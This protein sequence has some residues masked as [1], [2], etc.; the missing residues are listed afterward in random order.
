VPI[1]DTYRFVSKVKVDKFL[2]VDDDHSLS[3]NFEKYIS[4]LI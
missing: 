1:E 4:E 3:M 2:E